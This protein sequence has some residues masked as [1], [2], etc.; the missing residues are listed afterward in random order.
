MKKIGHVKTLL[1]TASNSWPISFGKDSFLNLI[2]VVFISVNE[3]LN[4]L[5]EFPSVFYVPSHGT[6]I[7]QYFQTY[8]TIFYLLDLEVPELSST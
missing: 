5:P 8:R 2:N 4:Q 3:H 6:L 7:S 1:F